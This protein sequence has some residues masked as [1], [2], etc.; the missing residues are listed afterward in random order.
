MTPIGTLCFPALF[1]AK[2]NKENPA[3]KPRYSCILL[4]DQTAIET[5][6]YK[7]L[8]AAVQAAAA[9]KFGQA[10]AA[11]ANFMRSLRLPFRKSDEKDYEGFDAGVIYISPWTAGDKTRPGV[12]DLHGNDILVPGDVWAGQKARAT[13]RAFAYDSN[14]NKGVS[15]GLEH[16]QI[17][18][19]DEPRIDG[20]RSAESAFKDADNSQFAALGI[21]ASAAPSQA[22]DSGEMP[23]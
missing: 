3:Q 14:G 10:K 11:D 22:A 16:V 4:F 18:K 19:A 1:E 21:D 13:V 2:A 6:Q 9:E 12:V 17:V 23:W 20:R 15:F 5:T 8:R 7:A